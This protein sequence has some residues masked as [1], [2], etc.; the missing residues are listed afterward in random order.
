M[1]F[2]HLCRIHELSQESYLPREWSVERVSPLML[3]QRL[4][5]EECQ[6]AALK[7]ALKV[8][9]CKSIS[10]PI[11]LLDFCDGVSGPMAASC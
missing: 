9:I 5:V 8:H 6:L 2:R 10:A 4:F 3:L 7:V 1:Q 11:C